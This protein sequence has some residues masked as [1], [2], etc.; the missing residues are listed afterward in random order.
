[1]KDILYRELVKPIV[2]TFLRFVLYL[3]SEEGLIFA[4]IF[5]FIILGAAS[6][7]RDPNY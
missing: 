4:F 5:I 7:S 6:G 3:L 2:D 1:M